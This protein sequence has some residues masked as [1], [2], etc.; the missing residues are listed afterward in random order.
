MQQLGRVGYGRVG[1]VAGVGVT[2]L[3]EN[4]ERTFLLS[5]TLPSGVVQATRDE[6]L[7][8]K[9]FLK[10]FKRRSCPT[11][12]VAC[13]LSQTRDHSR[14]VTTEREGGRGGKKNN[15]NKIK[16]LPRQ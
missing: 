12:R 9:A 11:Q 6:V 3:S 7:A 10:S 15:N 5:S 1:W 4:C 2:K 8:K 13:F 14:D 16:R